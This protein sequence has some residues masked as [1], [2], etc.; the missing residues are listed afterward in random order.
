MKMKWKDNGK[1]E[2]GCVFTVRSEEKKSNE[3]DISGG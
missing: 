1:I 2:K 3:S